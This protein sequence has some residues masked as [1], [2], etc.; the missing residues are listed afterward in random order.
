MHIYNLHQWQHS[1]HFYIDD[2]SAERNTRRV[3]VL[4]VSM[5]LAEI[6][7]G[8]AFGS[9]ALLADGWHMGTHAIALGITA[10]AYYYARKHADNPRYSFGT[11]KVGVLG[12]FTSSVVLAVV[13][14]LMVVESIKRFLFPVE[15]QFNQAIFVAIIGLIVN[16][17]SALLL[18][19]GHGHSHRHRAD[20]HHHHDHNLRAA[21][22]H[23]MADALTSLLAIVAL[24]TGKAFGWI[25]MDPFMGIV[26][27]SLITRW[28]YGLLRDTGRILLDSGVKQEKIKNILSKIESDSD[29][30]V[31]DF[32][33]W[34]LGAHSFAVIISIVTHYPK[35][36]EYYKELLVG[37]KELKHVTVEVNEVDGD[38]CLIQT[39][40]NS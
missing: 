34:P 1:H 20:K 11:G 23:V 26:G 24:Y 2:G 25:W 19:G 7:A 9:M 36:P 16:I 22:L 14:V 31:S 13:A 5:M 33:I 30:R 29:S 38:P 21:Y 18:Q 8:I 10:F 17:I 28:A 12:G 6:I 15:I 4:T 35:S 3:I 27:A 40:N 32:H 39:E 37:F